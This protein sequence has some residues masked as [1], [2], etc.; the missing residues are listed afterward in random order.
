MSHRRSFPRK[1]ID[2]VE[3]FDVDDG[4]LRELDALEEPYEYWRETVLLHEW[5]RE[6][7]IYVHGAPQP[8]GFTAV[9]FGEW[10]IVARASRYDLES[11]E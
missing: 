1:K 5:G 10:R 2:F 6:V 11:R 3:V 4:K 9:A 7:E 8:E